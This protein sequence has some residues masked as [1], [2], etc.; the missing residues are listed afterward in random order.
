MNL[1]THQICICCPCNCDP[2]PGQGLQRT[3]WGS[4]QAL[5][6]KAQLSYSQLSNW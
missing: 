1:F 4:G 6:D 5:C 2:V 3:Q